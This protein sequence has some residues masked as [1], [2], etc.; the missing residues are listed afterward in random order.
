MFGKWLTKLGAVLAAVP[1]AWKAIGAVILIVI[2][3]GM[4]MVLK[5]GGK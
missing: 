3:A 4:A 5:N 2:G 1:L